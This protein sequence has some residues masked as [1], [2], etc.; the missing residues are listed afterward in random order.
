MSVDLKLALTRFV[1]SKFGYEATDEEGPF[2]QI[3]R[4]FQDYHTSPTAGHTEWYSAAERLFAD[5]ETSDVTSSQIQKYDSNINQHLTHINKTREDSIS[6]RYYQYISVLLTE[7]VLDQYDK[8]N[9][10][11]EFDKYVKEVFWQVSDKDIL[12]YNNP[13]EF[14]KLA[15]WM[16]TGSGKTFVLHINYLQYIQYFGTESFDN[17][18][19]IS[20][21]HQVAEQNLK[22]LQKSNINSCM[23]GENISNENQILQVV[24]ISSLKEG[25]TGENTFD[26]NEFGS[27]NV[28]FVDEGH[29]GLSSNKTNSSGWT[30][31]RNALTENGFAFEYSATFGSALADSNNNQYAEYSRS[32]L[33]DYSYGKFHEDQYGK[34]F[35]IT[36]ISTSED[37]SE[38]IEDQKSEWILTNFVAYYEKLCLFDKEEIVSKHNIEK[39]LLL[40]IGSTVNSS[41]T[42]DK[43]DIQKVV[44][45][46][47]KFV[48]DSDW[49]E[50]RLDEII[51]GSNQFIQEEFFSQRFEHLQ[52]EYSTAEQL[53]NEMKEKMFESS[54]ASQ[55]QITHLKNLEDQELAI[56]TTNAPDSYCGVITVG[57]TSEL[58][59][60][61]DES[62]NSIK[63]VENDINRS[64]QFDQIDADDT[65]IKFLIGSKKFAEG[66]NSNRPSMMGL[67]NVGVNEGAMILQMF[68]RGV[69]VEGKDNNGK[70]AT[71]KSLKDTEKYPVKRLE[72]LDVFGIRAEYM[73]TF[74]DHLRKEKVSLEDTETVEVSIDKSKPDTDSELHVPYVKESEGKIEVRELAE[75]TDSEIDNVLSLDR[76]YNSEFLYPEKEIEVTGTSITSS[77]ETTFESSKNYI[78]IAEDLQLSTSNGAQ[79]LSIDVLDWNKI[80]SNVLQYKNNRGYD[81]LIIHKKTVYMIINQSKYNLYGPKRLTKVNSLDRS[82]LATV[83]SL[84]SEIVSRFVNNVY[85][86][87]KK[88]ATQDEIGFKRLDQ[89][90]VDEHISEKYEV[91]VQKSEDNRSTIEKLKELSNSINENDSGISK[92][93]FKYINQLY[94][95]VLLES[96]DIKSIRPEGLNEGEE[97]FITAI[98]DEIDKGVLEDKEVLIMRNQPHQG[99]GISS[100]NGME[101][102]DF[103]LWITHNGQQ[104]IIFADPHGM[105]LGTNEDTTYVLD[106][107]NNN[108][109]FGSDKPILHAC[110]FARTKD[111]FK[112]DSQRI[113][114][115]VDESIKEDVFFIDDT[116]KDIGQTTEQVRKML[117][118]YIPDL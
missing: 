100:L 53:Y 56:S 111:S 42:D 15:Y 13:D 85:T 2:M 63:M 62:D 90:W 71:Y 113:K 60:L 28:I 98:E 91:E 77:E 47:D 55:L 8:D 54:S 18:I 19:L 76:E 108:K 48:S 26:V 22:E 57:D 20:P 78:N 68:G 27:N 102:P 117:K 11:S 36:N 116:S 105:I 88:E 16:A 83:E 50:K 12:P 43:T 17:A 87:M 35:N 107:I 97:K 93:I 38:Y 72:T 109:E 92:D 25:E 9:F 4:D 106:D 49:V 104:H 46:F 118:R 64:S 115:D 73:E 31:M 94:R 101:Y 61:L 103:V 95:P 10:V 99:V 39:P 23:L 65:S 96:K 89:Q 33:F 58:Y 84:C 52:R 14:G 59:N 7:Y 74:R 29:K 5:S 80:W 21:N 44:E 79:N 86:L 75:F 37:L 82:D 30:S 1:Y 34:D 45:F 24:S 81:E 41:S 110:I 69:R 32:I 66:W 51:S 70:R 114:N 40:F 3:S 67:L 112:E 6:L